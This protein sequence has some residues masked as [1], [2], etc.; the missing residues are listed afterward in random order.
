ML[1]PIFVTT[2]A[3][4][5]QVTVKWLS[6]NIPTEGTAGNW[7][8]ASGSDVQHL[9]MAIDGTLYAYGKSLTYTLYK[10]TD[11][12]FSWSHIGKVNDAIVDIAT[13]PENAS[14]IYYATTANVYK[15]TN[16]GKSFAS[17]PT[18]P[19]GAGSNNIE[20]TSI[21]TAQ[22]GIIAVGTRDTDNAQYGGV[23][24]LDESESF[25]WVDT[26]IGNYDVY[27]VAYSH[28]SAA[29][30]QLIAVATDEANTIITSR[31]GN[32]G[33]GNTIGNATINGVVPTSAS[34]AFPDDYAPD[35]TAGANVFFTAI[36]AS[37][38]GDV[39]KINN[40][41]AP[42]SSVATDLN[43]GNAY[44]LSNVDVT[45]LAVNGNAATAYLLAGVATS[46]QVYFSTDGG[47]NWTV[48]SKPPTGQ[49]ATC[50]LTAPDFTSSGK[51]YAA[52]TGTESALSY[53][54]DGGVTW[55][56]T[57]LI[58]TTV[59]TI[60]D[61]AP[62]PNYS[63]DN[64]LFLLT[65]GGEHSLWRSLN[66]G[67]RWERVFGSAMTSVDS[68]S[69]VGLP[70]QYENGNQ[71]IFLAGE[72]SGDPAIWKSTDNG[73]TFSSPFITRDPTTGATFTTDAWAIAD[74][75]TLFIGS[76]DG[77]NG[78]VYRSN[79]SGLSYF[80]PTEAGS[81]TLSSIALSPGYERDKTI[82][83]G[84]S[85]GWIYWSNDNGATFEPL[86]PAAA[87]APLSGSITVAFDAQFGSNNTIYA[88]SDA[89]NEG[90]YRFIIGNETEWERIDSTLATGGILKKII[91]SADGTLYATNFDGDGGMERC[92]NPT[93]PL[94]PTFEAVTSGLDS[95]ATLSG[96]WLGENRL[97]AIDTTNLKLMTYIDSLSAGVAGP[98]L[99]S[100]ANGSTLS[101]GQATRFTIEAMPGVTAYDVQWSTDITFISEV[102]NL[103]IAAPSVQTATQANI[104][105]GAIVYWRARATAPSNS[106]WSEVWTFE[107]QLVTEVIAPVPAY[108]TG[109][110][111]I[112]IPIKPVFNWSSFKYA[113][114]YEFQLAND[115]GMTNLL[116]DLTGDSALGPVTSYKLTESLD[117]NIT[118]YWRVRA[119]RGT[120]TANS[121]WSA[122]IGFI[123]KPEP[124][125]PT[126]P[127]IIEPAP[128]PAPAPAPSTPVYIWTIIAI[129]SALVIVVI[130]LMIRMPL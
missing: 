66:G 18:N 109:D 110:D 42:N 45:S 57:S 64:T 16:T 96:L 92:L 119:I 61:L 9:T 47:S 7:V 17:L 87:S 13:A 91:A 31:V 81:Q 25:I 10:S 56:Q 54:V 35:I 82:L 95:G 113:T 85:S 114:G 68:L 69:L 107:T 115:S 127:V 27:T 22:D 5:D 58:D 29:G 49:T 122:V 83:T 121:D 23:Y 67:A 80:T 39:Y 70:P 2:P 21:S 41:S 73:K 32:G 72:S 103:A 74:D 89:A 93:Y 44:S 116:V 40:I 30:S 98:K 101:T 63:Q 130:V 15:S 19:G 55:S 100:P 102:T 75:T 90:I 65:W 50:V 123:T 14:I 43:I 118:Y 124:T 99:I 77:S 106:A 53:T 111:A 6:T 105:E 8:L 24:T 78:L 28:G 11:G 120:S 48:S 60:V 1:C 129:V 86:P 88:A 34:V 79:N 97:W 126:P 125:E 112:N 71:V 33:W 62:S 37:G 51:A 84:N 128:A 4:A 76:F 38:N 104:T 46:A 20:I 3:I 94:G 36:S 108:P 59:T 117:Y 52:T 12:G 26:T